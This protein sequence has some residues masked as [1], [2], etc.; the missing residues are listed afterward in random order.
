MESKKLNKKGM[1]VLT[2]F[3]VCLIVGSLAFVT[4]FSLYGSITGNDEGYG[5]GYLSP[6]TDQRM[7]NISSK[8]EEALTTA[9]ANAR[10]MQQKFI[11]SD[12]SSESGGDNMVTNAFATVKDLF[13]NSFGLMFGLITNTGSVLNVD[14]IWTSALITIIILSVLIAVLSGFMKA[15]NW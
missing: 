8:A 5:Y 7:N 13:K 6:N 11:G 4:I 2:T 14:K 15:P 10:D 1:G 12:A 3:F 9:T